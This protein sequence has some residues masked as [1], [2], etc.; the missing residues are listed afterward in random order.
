MSSM[1]SSGMRHRFGGGFGGG[2]FWSLEL[3]ICGI[4]AVFCLLGLRRRVTAVIACDA[5]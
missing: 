3:L 2:A 5:D 1:R 4:L